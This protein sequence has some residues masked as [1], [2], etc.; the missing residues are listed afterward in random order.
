M[1]PTF[2]D[3]FSRDPAAYAAFRPRYPS[4]LFLWLASLVPDHGQAWDAGTGNGQAAVALADHF[5]RVIAT[6][7]SEAQLTHAEPHPRVEYLRAG[8]ETTLPA[9]SIDLVTVAQALHWFDRPRFWAE[10]RRV[11]RGSGAVVVWCY[12][13][14]RVGP[15]IDRV[16]NRFY[17]HTVGPYWPPDRKLVDEGYRSIEFPF[18]ESPTPAF[19]MALEWTLDQQMGYLGTWSAVG[20]ARKALGTDPLDQVRPELEAV[21]PRGKALRVEW[22]LS[23][24]AGYPETPAAETT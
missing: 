22:P 9:G 3:H 14:Q 17:H 21:W 10:V 12:G 8:E 4:E 15:D 18:R 2:K 19:S 7:P 5:E 16:I 6:D 1:S 24:R 13:L 23:F 11:L 20:R